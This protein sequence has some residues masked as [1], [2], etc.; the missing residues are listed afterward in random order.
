MLLTLRSTSARPVLSIPLL[1]RKAA[2]FMVLGVFLLVLVGI[3]VG[4]SP[5]VGFVR[6]WVLVLILCVFV[7][8]GVTVIPASSF[9]PRGPLSRVGVVPFG[10]FDPFSLESPA[11]RVQVKSALPDVVV[12]EF[13]GVRS[14]YR[15]YLCDVVFP[16]GQ[17]SCVIDRRLTD[18]ELK[19]GL[20]E[21]SFLSAELA[22]G[23]VSISLHSLVPVSAKA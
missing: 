18:P 16:D 13:N 7:V 9:V 23:R 6:A 1:S 20:Y 2:A 12:K 8:A 22:R 14:E 5:L 10:S 15:R 4:F 21:P 17:T 19:P 11:M 3:G